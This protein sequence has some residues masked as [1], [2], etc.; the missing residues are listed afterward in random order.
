[1][2]IQIAEA[3]DAAHSIGLIHRDIKPANVLITPKGVAKVTDFGLAKMVRFSSEEIDREA[4]T[5][6]ATPKRKTNAAPSTT[7]EGAREAAGR[8]AEVVNSIAANVNDEKLRATFLNAVSTDYADLH[9]LW[10][11]GTR[12]E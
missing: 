10:T 5:L 3:L 1:M 7:R 12:G 4:Q 8:A 9:N 2:R 6:A 11:V